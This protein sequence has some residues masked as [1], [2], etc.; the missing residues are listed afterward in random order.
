MNFWTDPVQ[1]ILG[2]EQTKNSAASFWQ[3]KLPGLTVVQ[4]VFKVKW[5]DRGRVRM[6]HLCFSVG[7]LLTGRLQWFEF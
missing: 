1:G 7:N 2:G 5:A 4:F 3:G 6:G